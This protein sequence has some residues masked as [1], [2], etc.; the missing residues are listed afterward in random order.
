MGKVA[1]V[2]GASSGIGLDTAL[3]LLEKGY[4]VYGAARRVDLIKPLVDNGGAA[5][6]L[7]L[8][9]KDSIHN[10][11]QAILKK[12]GHIDLLVNNAGF[13]L[14]GAIEDVPVDEA[15]RQFEVNVFGLA[16]ITKEVLPSMRENKSGKIINISSIAGR[17]SSPFLGW[18]H[19]TKYSVEAFSD[20]LRL[21]VKPF[22][23]KVVIIEPGMIKTPWG[24]IAA[25]NMRKYSENTDYSKYADTIAKYYEKNYAEDGHI[26]EP[27]VISKTIVKAALKKNPKIRYNV[28]TGS[29]TILFL[30]KIF[31][32]PVFDFGISKA[33]GLK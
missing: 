24:K 33:F 21:E 3:R 5:L 14:G 7:D 12:E 31:R 18:Y 25:E 4:M 15:R 8:T 27:S 10:C 32:D 19:A 20:A 26:S 30:K 23:I 29:K 28:G 16:E 2:T 13:G 9:D 6:P 22:G 1:L 17:F 11:V